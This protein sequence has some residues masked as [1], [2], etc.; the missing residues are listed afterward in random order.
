MHAIEPTIGYVVKLEQAWHD[1]TLLLWLYVH[2]LLG[3]INI[4]SLFDVSLVQIW[5]S[6]LMYNSE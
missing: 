2:W 1:S 6:R 3:A 5:T 4:Y